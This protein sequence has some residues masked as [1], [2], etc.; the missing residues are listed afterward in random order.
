MGL[1]DYLLSLVSRLR[2]SVFAW[3]V[4]LA[5]PSQAF[6]HRIAHT[7]SITSRQASRPFGVK[8]TGSYSLGMLARVVPRILVRRNEF[9]PGR[10][11]LI[12]I[13]WRIDWMPPH[14]GRWATGLEGGGIQNYHHVFSTSLGAQGTSDRYCSR[15]PGSPCAPICLELGRKSGRVGTGAMLGCSSGRV[16]GSWSRRLRS[17]RAA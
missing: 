7:R 13:G 10:T 16:S 11:S 15:G 1:Y 6:C 14:F 9:V 4:Y 12:R 17:G 2:L 3:L 5:I 8:G